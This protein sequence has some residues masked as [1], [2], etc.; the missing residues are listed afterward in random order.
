MKHY[1]IILGGKEVETERKINVVNPYNKQTIATV[2]YG[3]ESHLNRAIEKAHASFPL[4]ST[5]PSYKRAEICFFIASQIRSKAE[6]LVWTL[7]SES[8]KPLVYAKTEVNRV[9]D[10]FTIAGEEA[11]RIRGEF[12]SLDAVASG[13]NRLSITQHFS[14]GVVAG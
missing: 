4:T 12:S 8:A 11:K 7:A 10:T 5:L 6:E 2:S 1:P 3:D 13:V 14:E 9:I